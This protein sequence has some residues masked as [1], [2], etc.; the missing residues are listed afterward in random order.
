MRPYLGLVSGVAAI[1][2]VI[3]AGSGVAWAQESQLAREGRGQ[4]P[5]PA[6]MPA[7]LQ[8]AEPPHT[9]Q[10]DP[11]GGFSRIIFET[12]EDPNFRIVIRDF[13]FPPD[14]QT[15][16]VNL[17]SAAFLHF[18]GESGQVKE[19]AQVKIANQ[20]LRPVSGARTAAPATP[21]EVINS[22]EQPV[23]VRALIVEAK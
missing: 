11:S 18:V 13:S 12:D 16:I 22:G 21:I 14:R 6:E 15:H 20:P 7:T 1:I 9:F 4:L 19:S 2:V 3:V 23:V 17:P 8:G 5:K 10:P